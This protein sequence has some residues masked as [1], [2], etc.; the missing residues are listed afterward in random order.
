MRGVD[1]VYETFTTH[2]AEGRNLPV[3]K[4]LDIGRGRVW[5]GEDALGI[6]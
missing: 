2:V 1:K 5:S 6:V 3:E 4:V